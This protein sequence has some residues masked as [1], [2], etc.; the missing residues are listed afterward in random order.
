MIK[1]SILGRVVVWFFFR[2][3]VFIS[4]TAAASASSSLIQ[5]VCEKKQ[6]RPTQKRQEKQEIF[7]II[8]ATIIHYNI[9]KKANQQ[10]VEN[11]T[12]EYKEHKFL[13]EEKFH[14]IERTKKKKKKMSLEG[15]RFICLDEA[16]NHGNIVMAK[17][18]KFSVGYY[19]SCDLPIADERAKG[20]HCTIEC[21]AFGR[22]SVYKKKS[23][24]HV[25]LF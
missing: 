13:I 20:I 16:G 14:V 10:V 12:R 18:R 17:G 11:H 21:D 4:T 7:A 6:R 25:F 19:T 22:V 3:L 8:T 1:L 2:S 9:W 24:L 23:W 5:F 15:A